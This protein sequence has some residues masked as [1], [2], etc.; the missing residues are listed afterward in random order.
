MFSQSSWSALV[1]YALF[2]M[3]A[4]MHFFSAVLVPMYTDW[5]GL[6]ESYISIIQAW[7]MI[8]GLTLDVPT[9]IFADRCGRKLSL[10]L[11]ALI[12]A[13]GLVIYGSYPS[14]YVFIAGE[15]ILALGNKLMQGA[16]QALLFSSV[17]EL[18][19]PQIHAG[20]TR[21]ILIIRRITM[22]VGS[23][24]GGFIASAWGFNYPIL[25]SAIPLLIAAIIA[26]GFK[27]VHRTHVITVR[28]AFREGYRE[29][30]HNACVRGLMV[31]MMISSVPGYFI[32]WLYQPLLKRVMFPITYYGFAHSGLLVAQITILLGFALIVRKLGSERRY[33]LLSA[34]LSSG[35]YLLAAYSLSAASAI[36][37]IAIGGLFTLT[38]N[39]ILR[40]YINPHVTPKYQATVVSYI[41]MMTSILV[42]VMNIAVSIVI[43][44]SFGATLLMIGVFPLLSLLFL[45]KA[46]CFEKRKEE[47]NM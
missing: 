19:D 9:G 35:A 16:D 18:K 36:I 6:D 10:I 44:Y 8:G 21:I 14:I 31:Q 45:P 46:E 29:V 40:G 23:I 37:F 39:D 2:S 13:C 41:G 25:C 47:G 34:I 3:F 28:D 22:I 38:R 15:L 7:F 26:L 20:V 1:R 43:Q 27:E 32:L 33:L 24:A 4:S 11:G 17:P 5:A 30:H 42:V 12:C